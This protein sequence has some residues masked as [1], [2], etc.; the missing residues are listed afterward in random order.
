MNLAWLDLVFFGILLLTA[1]WGIFR[2][3]SV[4]LTI[5]IVFLGASLAALALTLPVENL[6]LRLAG[7]PESA[8]S[9]APPL[10]TLI[11]ADKE[12]AAFIAAITP[13]IIFLSTALVLGIIAKVLWKKIHRA[14]PNLASRL[15]AIPIGLLAGAV[16]ALALAVQISRLPWP[17][18]FDAA[19]ESL[20]LGL[21]AE[22]APRLVPTV[23]GVL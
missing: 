6:I 18:V 3:A 7:L 4:A 23:A 16:P 19:R 2:G 13:G 8:A 22:T 1:V 20:V 10:M 9:E 11:L 5:L 12:I 21:L 14:P 15:I 17:P